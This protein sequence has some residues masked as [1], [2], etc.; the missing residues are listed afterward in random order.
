MIMSVEQ[1]LDCMNCECLKEGAGLECPLW[2]I[3]GCPHKCFEV[4]SGDKAH[5]PKLVKIQFA[6]TGRYTFKFL[7]DPSVPH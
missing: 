5:T 6:A 2:I 3:L 4:H 7:I 1:V